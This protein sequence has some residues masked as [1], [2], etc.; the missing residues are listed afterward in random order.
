MYMRLL[1]AFWHLKRLCAAGSLGANREMH[2]ACRVR[3]RDK[4]CSATTIVLEIAIQMSQFL[5]LGALKRG[6]HQLSAVPN[7]IS[8]TDVYAQGEERREER[9][10]CMPCEDMIIII[11]ITIRM[12][13]SDL[14][15][16]RLH[17]LKIAR[18]E[19]W[20]PMFC[21]I[22]GRSY[23]LMVRLIVQVRD[24]SSGHWLMYRRRGGLRWYSSERSLG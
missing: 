23:R 24:G 11:S 22:R 13:S 10:R 21:L 5:P 16:C 14:S 20:Q 15:R 19:G 9:R 6:F 12:M 8:Q 7:S 1:L 4:G 17:G 18:A 2:S 3:M